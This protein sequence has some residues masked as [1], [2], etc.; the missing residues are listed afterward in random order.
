[1]AAVNLRD[2][3]FIFGCNITLKVAV[4]S[5]KCVTKHT[6]KND[7]VKVKENRSLIAS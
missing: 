4:K 5:Q 6:P 1:M 2:I 3:I 7:H